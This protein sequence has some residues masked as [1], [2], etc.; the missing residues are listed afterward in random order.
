M[1]AAHGF[2]GW[3]EASSSARVELG[4]LGNRTLPWDEGPFFG[5]SHFHFNTRSASRERWRGVEAPAFLWYRLECVVRL[6]RGF[7]LDL[8]DL[9]SPWRAG[10]NSWPWRGESA[11][12]DGLRRR[13]RRPTGTTE[14]YLL[15]SGSYGEKML[16][17][18]AAAAAASGLWSQFRPS[19]FVTTQKCGWVWLTPYSPDQESTLWLPVVWGVGY[20]VTKWGWVKAQ[21]A[22]LDLICT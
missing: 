4:R 7:T 1:F 22:G 10:R 19:V 2:C 8:A 6:Q 14:S 18:A 15:Q 13:E 21:W 3:L 11:H 17:Q 16:Q 5:F 20:A 12:T 9:L